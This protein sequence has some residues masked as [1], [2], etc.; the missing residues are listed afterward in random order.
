LEQLRHRIDGLGDCRTPFGNIFDEKIAEIMERVEPGSFQVSEFADIF[1]RRTNAILGFELAFILESLEICNR[2]L[3]VNVA[4]NERKNVGY[5]RAFADFAVVWDRLRTPAEGAFGSPS[6]IR[7]ELCA[8]RQL[9]KFA[10]FSSVLETSI[11]VRREHRALVMTS[12]KLYAEDVSLRPT[13]GRQRPNRAIWP[14]LGQQL[15]LQAHLLNFI[16]PD[17]AVDEPDVRI[18]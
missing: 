1:A 3:E 14:T 5:S 12:Y 13:L 7:I 11:G 16:Q 8:S 17:D 18:Q 2:P 4:D 6:W 15:E 9:Q 10:R